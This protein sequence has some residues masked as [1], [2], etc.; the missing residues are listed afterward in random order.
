MLHVP[1]EYV[2]ALQEVLGQE[3]SEN[4]LRTSAGKK[5][6]SR[7]AASVSELSQG[8][9]KAR[10]A[11]LSERYL[12]RPGEREAYLAYFT[13]TNLLKLWPP[14]RELAR[15]GFFAHRERLDHLDLGTG[16]GAAIWSLAT[17]LATEHPGLALHTTAAD[18]VQANLDVTAR[19]AKMLKQHLP[20]I[21][22]D[23]TTT[24]SQLPKLDLR[25]SAAFDLITL[26]NVVNELPEEQDAQ[27]I[28]ALEKLLSENGTVIMI[29]P[30]AREP[31]R[32]ALRFRDRMVEEGF[33]VYSPCTRSGG[34]PALGND[35]DWCH[36]AF[37]W[38]RPAFIRLID[39][40]TGNLRLT[41]KST[42][43]VFTRSEVNLSDVLLGQRD[44][45]AAGRVVSD[46]FKEK[47]RARAF[48]CNER[49]RREYLWMKRDRT[50]ANREMLELQR[51]DLVQ[52]Q[53]VEERE[54]DVRVG[55]EAG[56]HRIVGAD[57][58]GYVDK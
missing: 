34:C 16:T 57:G 14:L 19:F 40:L 39:D 48:I 44:F 52:I 53:G 7:I 6:L 55:V 10:T 33:H 28:A 42:Y 4:A 47:G 51:Y 29:E 50:V 58:C 56:I 36:T 38:E 45:F 37:D 22:M 26:M 23:V 20:S 12:E 25:A 8:L 46:L 18:H 31:S 27:L 24:R 11:F 13:T 3:L 41:L 49:G 30:S 54:S 5:W 35:G 15:C 17:W 9:T 32:R 1:V 21:T 43:A 2:K